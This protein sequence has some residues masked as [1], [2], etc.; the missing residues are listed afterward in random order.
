MNIYIYIYIYIN[1]LIIYIFILPTHARISVECLRAYVRKY[2][3]IFASIIEA[4]L[5]SNTGCEQF[6]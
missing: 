5:V 2:W 1:F 4:I 6:L 3:V